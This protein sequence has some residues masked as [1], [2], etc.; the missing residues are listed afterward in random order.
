MASTKE[1]IHDMEAVER[2]IDRYIESINS[3]EK[4]LVENIWLHEDFVSF[5]APAGYFKTLASIRDD[6]VLGIFGKNFRKRCLR[7]KELRIHLNGN[8]AWAEFTWSF[9]AVKNDGEEV[10]S[11]GFE[12]QVLQKDQRG[13][14]KL[15]HVHYSAI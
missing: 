5:T 9:E 11:R 4:E 3:C 8:M 7:K 6:F 12:T 1:N 13:E 15:V 14:W 2:V 10:R